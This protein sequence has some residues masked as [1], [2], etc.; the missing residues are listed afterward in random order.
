MKQSFNSII[1]VC[2]V[3]FVFA[4]C[5]ETNKPLSVIEGV[6]MGTTYTVK[7][8]DQINRE[9]NLKTLID[10]EL[11]EFNKVFSN[12]IPDSEI[13]R[14]N[15]SEGAVP[16]SSSFR[17]LLLLSEE[18][19]NITQGAFDV[20]IGPL[21]NL[22]GFGP[23]SETGALPSESQVQD[24]LET[25]G[26]N[27]LRITQDFVYKAEETKLDF[28]GIAKGYAVDSIVE[29]LE[30]MGLTNFFVE[31]GGEVKARGL[32]AR[33]APWNIGIEVPDRNERKIFNTV[34]LHNLAMATSG[35]YRNFFELDDVFFSHII[36]PDSGYPIDNRVGSVTVLHPSAALADA[37]ATGLNA[38]GFESLSRISNEKNLKVMAIIRRSGNYEVFSSE[39]YQ[40][41]L[42]SHSK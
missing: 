8:A 36:N 15:R 13:S 35:D 3:V 6:T 19:K 38:I 12:Y 14:F 1:F 2:A 7:I 9:V 27:P 24:L 32:N 26:S 33:G 18:V 20:S 29:T 4:G 40:E 34:P 5:S 30:E 39:K 23:V 16:I 10:Q 37:L 41:Y 21:V 22:W 17:K 25:S 28:S 11:I 31:I 42:K